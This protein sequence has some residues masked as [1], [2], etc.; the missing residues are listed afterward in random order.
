MRNTTFLGQE[1]FPN[2]DN[3]TEQ[4]GFQRRKAYMLTIFC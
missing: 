1:Q 4:V 3:M 2:P